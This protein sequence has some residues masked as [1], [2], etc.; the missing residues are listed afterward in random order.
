M[1]CQCHHPRRAFRTVKT[2]PG[3]GFTIDWGG[4]ATNAVQAIGS[5]TIARNALRVQQAQ[6]AAALRAQETEFQ[7]MQRRQ[8]QTVAQ[9]VSGFITTP[10]GQVMQVTPAGGYVPVV[11][12]APSA[13]PSWAIP[14]AVGVGVL[15]LMRN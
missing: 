7:L 11:Q 9:P 13:L 3:L 1:K 8:A 4:L 14:A 6:Q 15:F 12:R 5:V 10:Q 2:A